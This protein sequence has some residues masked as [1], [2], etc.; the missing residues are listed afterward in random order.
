[1]GHCLRGRL[2]MSISFGSDIIEEKVLKRG[3]CLFKEGDSVRNIYIVLNG[4]IA[5]VT[6]SD[7]RLIPLFVAGPQDFVGEEAMMVEAY[8]Y[9]AVALDNTK[10]IYFHKTDIKK[11]FK[12]APEWIEKMM[13]VLCERLRATQNLIS[14]HKILDNTIT[15][16]VELTP[17]DESF[18]LQSIK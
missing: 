3:E 6:K 17:K 4:K 10:V 2:K 1:M 14:E 5:G 13:K 7:N 12:S 8:H 18:I 11:Y 16:G 15:K 9:S